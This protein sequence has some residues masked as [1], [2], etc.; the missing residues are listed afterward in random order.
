M[1]QTKALSDELLLV[2]GD[3]AVLLSGGFRIKIAAIW[4]VY[5]NTHAH[6]HAQPLH[7]IYSRKLSLV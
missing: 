5:M 2:E 7:Y 6:A 3:L 1:P 4:L